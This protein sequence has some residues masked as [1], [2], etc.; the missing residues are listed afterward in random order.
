MMGR[1]PGVAALCLSAAF[2]L[3]QSGA[4]KTV[5]VDLVNSVDPTIGGIGKLLNSTPALIQLPHGM[6][7]VMPA[8]DPGM[9]DWYVADDFYG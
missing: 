6:A 2:V 8:T 9:M 7:R 3:A 1:T 5:S 4:K